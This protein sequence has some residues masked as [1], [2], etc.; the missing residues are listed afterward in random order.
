MDEYEKSG[1]PMN[2]VNVFKYHDSKPMPECIS[3]IKS[4]FSSYKNVS[5]AINLF[6][7][8]QYI[9][10]HTDNYEKYIEINDV[11]IESIVRGIVMLEDSSIG[12]IFHIEDDCF[13]KWEAGKTFLWDY[14]VP[15]TFYNLSTK[16]RY[17]IQITAIK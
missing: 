16:K 12:Q 2:R 6:E 15:H 7:P 4:Q 9:P 8:A 14:N 17:A 5:V 13:G 10:Y 3:Y 1:H 11:K